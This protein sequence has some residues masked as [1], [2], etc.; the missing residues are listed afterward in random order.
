MTEGG[1]LTVWPRG[2]RLTSDWRATRTRFDVRTEIF[3]PFY[4]TKHH[5]TGLGLAVSRQIVERH[6]GTL[7]LE[8][9]PGGGATFI[10]ALPLA[11][12]EGR[13]S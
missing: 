12:P 6:Q 11:P 3:R 10:V 8:D 1:S 9:A 4:T 13:R 7:R 5:G 2:T